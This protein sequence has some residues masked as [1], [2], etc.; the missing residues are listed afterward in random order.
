MSTA[1]VEVLRDIESTHY[2]DSHLQDGLCKSTVDP[3]AASRCL[4]DKQLIGI[5]CKESACV[6]SYR[7]PFGVER[8]RTTVRAAAVGHPRVQMHA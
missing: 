5:P 4:A 1:Q 6:L 7:A 3:I 2:L 8:S